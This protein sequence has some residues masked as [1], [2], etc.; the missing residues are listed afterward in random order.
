MHTLL[1]S[2][3]GRVYSWGNNDDF[4]LGREGPEN[5][6]AEITS[7]TMPM[8]NICAGDSHSVT[9]NSDLNVL[10]YWGEYRV[11]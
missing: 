9:Y 5:V 11:L 8:S 1:L 6:P 10:Y 4:A 2:S 3:L 7:I